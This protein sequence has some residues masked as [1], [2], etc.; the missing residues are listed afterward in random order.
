[1][2]SYNEYKEIKSK[3]DAIV[4][5]LSDKLNSYPKGEFGMVEEKV[6]MSDEYREVNNQFNKEFKVLQNIHSTGMKLFKKEIR[7]EH[8]S[9]RKGK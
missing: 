4:S 7:K 9:K 2:T 3:Q 1:M 6:R 5:A 8:E